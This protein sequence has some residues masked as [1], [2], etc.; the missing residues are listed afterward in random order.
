MQNPNYQLAC[1]IKKTLVEN[2]V[3][4]MSLRR[5]KSNL[6]KKGVVSSRSSIEKVMGHW[7]HNF[8]LHLKKGFLGSKVIL[9]L[10]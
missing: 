6:L 10:S 3:L 4:N 1:E 9:V 8:Q 2:G 7:G 5:I